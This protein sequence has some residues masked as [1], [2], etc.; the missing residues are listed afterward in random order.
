M[1]IAALLSI[2][3]FLFTGGREA[4]V[5]DSIWLEGEAYS[6][7]NVKT[8]LSGWGKTDLL[9]GKKWLSISIDA[10]QVAK[11]LPPEGAVI[12]YDF[13]TAQAGPHE[14]WNRIGFEFVRSPFAWRV[15]SGK[16][17]TVTP[18]VLTS[19]MMEIDTWAEVAWLQMG[20]VDLNSGN[21]RLEIKL[22]ARQDAK[23][24]PERVLYAS[25]ALYISSGHFQPNGVHKPGVDDRTDQ[26]RA[27]A[28]KSFRVVDSV[29]ERRQN[30]SLNGQWEI[31][32]DDEQFPKEV[33]VPITSRPSHPIWSA[34]AVPGDKNTLRP[35]LTM[36]H[37]VWYRT[38][39][40]VP[41]SQ[42]GQSFSLTFNQ[43][44]LNTTVYVNDQFCGFNKNPF[45]KWTC[46]VSKAIHSGQNEVWV[47]IRDAW[48]G[49]STNPQDPMKLRRNFVMPLANQRMGFLDLAYPVWGQFASGILATPTL[50]VAGSLMV[51]DVFVKPSVAQKSLTS[52]VTLRNNSGETVSVAVKLEAVDPETGAVAQTFPPQTYDI[53]PGQEL[54]KS[55]SGAWANPKLWW[56][57]QGKM[58]S[59]RATVLKDG[60]PI[61]VSET[62]FGFR[63]WTQDG[64]RLKL[65]GVV[66]HGWAELNQGDT[67]E[68]YLK[69]YRN[70]HQRFARMSGASQNGG[71]SWLGMPYDQALD[72]CDR[73]GIVL[74]R[75]GPLD[76][77]AI[78]YM[79]IENDS[80][81]KALYKTE[82][83]QQLLDNVRDQMVA[84]VRGER[85]HPSVNIWSIENEW[86]Y[87]NCI[88]LYGG[89]MDDFES[90]MA[91]TAQA[92]RA[93]DPTR[94]VMTDGGGAGKSNLM[95]IHGDH[96]VYTG[97]PSDYPAKAYADFPEGGGRG[98]WVWD[99]KRPR[100]L[101][102]D[103][104]ASGINPAD[105]AYIQGESA[106]QGKV[107]AY[108]GIA[109]VQRMLTEGYRWNGTYTAWH[110]WLGDEGAKYGK[111]VS[112]SPR[113]VLV[114]EYDS[115]FGSGQTIK[116]TLKIL[117]DSFSDDPLEFAYDFTVHGK[118]IKSAKSIHRIQPG[119]AESLSISLLM[120][121][122]PSRLE[123][124]LT[125]SL[126][127]NG[128]SAFTDVKPVSVL[129]NSSFDA[130]EMPAVYDPAGSIRT[131]LSAH[132]VRYRPLTSLTV[133]PTAAKVLLI[134]KDAIS[135]LESTQSRLAAYALDGHRV[136]LLEQQNPLKFQA[137]PAEMEPSSNQGAFAF[138]E[139]LN[140]PAFS[141]L[142]Q[143]DFVGWGK[144][145]WVYRNAYLKPSKGA[146]SLVEV[147]SRL[148]NS[149]L[150]EV[151]VGTGLMILSQ[152]TI[153][154]NISTN[155]VAQNL[156]L[157]LLRYAN[158]YKLEHRAVASFTDSNPVFSE[159]LDQ[160]GLKHERTKTLLE[161]L[162]PGSRIAIVEANPNNL[163]TLSQVRDKVRAFTE[164]GGTLVL[165]G[166]TPV[167]LADYNRVVGVDHMIRPFRREKTS[168]AIPRSPLSSG[169]SL[170][171]AVM[172]SSE[173]MFDF[174]S[175][176]FVASDIFSYI[177]DVDDVAPFAKLP[178]SELY[179]TTNGFVSADGWKYIYSF[180]LK[181]QKPQ[182][183][184]EFP[185][186]QTFK[187][188]TWVGNGFYHKTTRIAL[189]F[190]CKVTREYDVQPTTEPQ[191]LI[192]T[193]PVM[194]K[195]VELSIRKW[196]EDPG[197]T[198]V[199][200]IDNVFLRVVRPVGFNQRVRSVLNVGGIVEYPLRKGSIVLCNL[201]FKPTEDVAENRVK[202][203]R[204]L[205]ALFHNMKATF[206]GERTVI[207]GAKL[208]YVP[209]DISKKANQYRND[210]G[211]FGDKQ[212]TFADLPTGRQVFS[213]IPYNVYD[214]PTS[215]VP[216]AIMLGGDG[217]PNGL[218]LAV[219][220]IK[221]GIKASA[222]FFL[223]TARIDQRRN[224][225]ELR[226]GKQN[227]L[228][229][230]V[231]HYQD[232]SRAIVP[233]LSELD[234]EDYRQTSPRQIAGAQIAWIKPYA[235]S[236]FK[237]V[238]YSKQWNNP[239]TDEE[240]MTIDLEYGP[241]RFGIPALLA[242]TAVK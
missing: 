49:F 136:I 115:A 212:Y 112:N 4:P 135:A 61:D 169:L 55:I 92:I 10:D 127:T 222:L 181:E 88:N 224:D 57:D 210:R 174:N 11:T 86:I 187:E 15:D 223:Q 202:K 42:I 137:I 28:S 114:K 41:A 21:H 177:V 123:G 6:N 182:Y 16:W 102:E 97:N 157:N 211:W 165:H 186:S 77:E 219:K 58:Y 68:S 173:R 119:T 172:L 52:D 9:S 190:D 170:G 54:T 94:L 98:R 164:A 217:I 73:H 33:A 80:Q 198:N 195:N 216:T 13:A 67:P 31:T 141:G 143:S 218:P 17:N 235:G 163:H 221:V 131:F 22:A 197:V 204:I 23:G 199:V 35:D 146:K 70:H 193:P 133:L 237:A 19:D 113:A 90:G 12:S 128:Q 148:G 99:K 124:Q 162:T 59:L 144:E 129:P 171:D 209:L 79:A 76:G 153:E 207:A 200:G 150:V 100:Y 201:L 75:N 229:R 20:S 215:P 242:I 32:R 220:D 8:N 118:S 96:Y 117:N 71:V 239:R 213:G 14:V 120:P 151:P 231:I 130:A 111:Y 147:S 69:N 18:E 53:Q 236:D 85:N 104:F 44:S 29:S 82:I 7:A 184:M 95:P 233:I 196:T 83:K 185:K 110:L 134:G 56:P 3:F 158:S 192:I 155:A 116:R 25:D 43:N 62:P 121:Q 45:V 51:S 47:G 50:T 214:F 138:A 107:E 34:I 167:G 139:N 72:W 188:F 38:R 176:M 179:N 105:Y 26:D 205:A 63:E 103:F 24:Q 161:A 191:V 234:V 225:Q 152:L 30:I 36:A 106:F 208:D 175:D 74:R 93:V 241:Q 2:P 91:K 125:L 108:E 189:N 140:H 46:D 64:Y 65:N 84:Q 230:Y 109:L 206:A 159:A 66:W 154:E 178:N 183:T 160:I 156:L 87:I 1:L 232:G 228:A 81:L 89:L 40:D 149:A 142:R 27:A 60:K 238:A 39:L 132:R 240:I 226:D 48:Y 5:G 168:I 145:G 122:T 126:R 78:G 101:G 37:R 166:L 203:R 227:E 180:S 194:A